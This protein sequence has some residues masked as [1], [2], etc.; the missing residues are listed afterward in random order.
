MTKQNSL[1]ESNRARWDFVR[2]LLGENVTGDIVELHDRCIAEAE[3]LGFLDF[4][5]RLQ[6]HDWYHEMSDDPGVYRSGNDEQKFLEAG[7]R[8]SD[9]YRAAFDQAKEKAGTKAGP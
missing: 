2:I 1:A 7:A 5:I 9:G 8:R 3:R 4:Y 6:R